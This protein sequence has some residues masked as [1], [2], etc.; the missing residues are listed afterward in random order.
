[1]G[2]V[3]YV[4]YQRDDALMRRLGMNVLSLD[5]DQDIHAFFRKLRAEHV[6]IVYVSEQ[7]YRDF[8][9]FIDHY[10]DDLMVISVLSMSA[11]KQ[12]H[13]KNRMKALLEEAVG[14]KKI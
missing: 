3:V 9:E 12:T 6:A 2:N 10:D 7:I 8:A 1:M 4:T 11:K 14:I 5:L 13:V